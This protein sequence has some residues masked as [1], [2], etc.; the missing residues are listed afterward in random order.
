MSRQISRAE[1]WE[2]T[3]KAFQSINFAAF[4]YNSVKQALIDYFKLYHSEFNNYIE[5]DEFIM[6]IE[7]F[8]YISELYAYRLDFVAHEKFIS[9]V[10][11]ID[12]V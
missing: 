10:H 5:S 2:Q 4:D 9:T 11:R 3:Y 1:G 12:S 8:A 7:A 6:M